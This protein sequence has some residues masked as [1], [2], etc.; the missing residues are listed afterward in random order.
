[1]VD[2]AL[3]TQI[4]VE[5]V[6][7]PVQMKVPAGTQSGTDFK[8]SSH[9]VPHLKGS[10]RGS[11]IVTILVDTPKKLTKEQ[12]KLLEDFQKNGAKKGLFR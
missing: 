1:M 5:T 8:L 7:G 9:G 12:V 4:E 6:D 11:H 10:S 3:G 2:A